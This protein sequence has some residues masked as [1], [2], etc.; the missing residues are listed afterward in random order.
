MLLI[1]FVEWSGAFQRPQHMALGFARRGWDVVHLCP[2]YLHRG[3]QQVDS[4]LDLPE[5][6]RVLKPVALPGARF[7]NAIGKLNEASMIRMIRRASSEP[8]D[9]IVFNDCRWAAA[10]ARTPARTK[11]WDLMDDLSAHAPSSAWLRE[12]EQ[13]ALKVADHVWTGTASLAER[14]NASHSHVR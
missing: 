6:L 13:D 12:R 11:I 9:A 1:S 10:A 7:W 2:G 8:W 3:R 5:S 14:F 4:G